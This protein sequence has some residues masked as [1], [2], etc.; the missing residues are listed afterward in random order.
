MNATGRTVWRAKPCGWRGR[1][2]VV[3]L[4]E[5]FGPAGPLVLD[6]L[7]EMA[8]EQVGDGSVRAG[9]RSLARDAFLPRGTE[10]AGQVRAILTLA[11]EVGALDDL[12]IADDVAMTVT[13][14][15]SGFAADQGRGYESVRKAKQ[16]AAVAQPASDRRDD[17]PDLGTEGD[18]VPASP[19]TGQDRTEEQP[20]V[21]A[22]DDQAT[23]P[24]ERQQPE[25][26]DRVWAAYIETRTAVLGAR[27]VPKLTPERRRLIAKRLKDWPE[28]DVVDA[29]R[30]W[31]HFPHNCGE[32][33]RRTPY[34]NVELVLRVNQDTNNVE[35]FRDAERQNAGSSGVADELQRLLI[36]RPPGWEERTAQLRETRTIGGGRDLVA[37]TARMLA[38]EAADL[39]RLD[40]DEEPDTSDTPTRAPQD[41]TGT[42][43]TRA[44]EPHADRTPRTPKNACE[45]QGDEG[46]TPAREDGTAM[47]AGTAVNDQAMNDVQAM[48]EHLAME[49]PLAMEVPGHD[50]SHGHDGLASVASLDPRRRRR[51]RGTRAA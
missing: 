18:S 14:R 39:A 43:E 15:V 34:C 13:C 47:N 12:Q 36:T 19:S 50:A 41:T 11:A 1:E 24:D 7:E 5:Q 38:E 17:V 31:R 45:Q 25:A 22:S 23:G 42:P 9:L 6:V 27:S 48:E 3:A 35:R 40:E 8:K 51:R 37:E 49:H 46:D 29:V 21:A 20:P 2:R 28:Q 32:N 33:D 10:G 44:P 30:G 4:G 16:R 26:V